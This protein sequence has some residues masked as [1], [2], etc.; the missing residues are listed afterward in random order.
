MGPQVCRLKYR[1]GHPLGLTIYPASNFLSL[2]IEIRTQIYKH[3]LLSPTPIQISLTPVPDLQ[4]LTYSLLK[5]NK[6]VSLEA[7]Q[8]L[9]HCNTFSFSR[10]EFNRVSP[11]DAD[12]WDVLFS[13]LH[14]IGP[15]NRTHLRNLHL[16][17]S[18]PCTVE[19]TSN[20][21]ILGDGPAPYWIRKVYP[22]DS[23]TRLHGIGLK[24]WPNSS[25]VPVARV[26]YVSPAIEAIFRLLGARSKLRI[27]IRQGD[28]DLPG[29]WYEEHGYPTGGVEVADHVES[30]RRAYG[31]AI[32]VL[33][34][35]WVVQKEDCEEQMEEI[36]FSG[37]EILGSEPL[38]RDPRPTAQRE[39]RDE[40]VFSM[41]SFLLWGCNIQ[42]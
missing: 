31:E 16:H 36:R 3:L 1:P 25:G 24:M 13:F 41:W 8:I 7:A 40:V 9:Y 38:V 5:V 37:W 26:D 22:R 28:Y 11:I 34:K 35:G 33:W 12:T 17:I 10:P 21:T 23:F 15:A 27:L 19:M 32:E 14:I 30:M 2:P 18:Y 4:P 29:V 6:T 39:P 42:C 20:G